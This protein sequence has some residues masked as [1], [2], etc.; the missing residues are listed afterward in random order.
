MPD[1]LEQIRTP[2]LLVSAKDDGYKTYTGAQYSA[3]H[4]PGARF[5][6]YEN[7]GHLLVGTSKRSW[8]RSR[9]C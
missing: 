4:M 8:R 6:G 9:N 7:G 1:D 2:T 5:V 3:D